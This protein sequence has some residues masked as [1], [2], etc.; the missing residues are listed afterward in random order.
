MD[1][2]QMAAALLK[3]LSEQQRLYERIKNISTQHCEALPTADA[4]ELMR[5]AEQKRDLLTQIDNVDRRI[6][7]LRRL[8]PRVRERIPSKQ[9]V[10]VEQAAQAVTALLKELIQ[11]EEKSQQIVK[12][13]RQDIKEGLKK[14]ARAK[15]LPDAYR[16]KGE[17][18]SRYI[19]RR[20]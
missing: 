2:Q 16:V 9:R 1:W 13:R 3:G 20:E 10:K 6:S 17:A 12:Q 11:L 7:E 4:D 15:K 5:F 18:Q 8:W 14:T 19:D